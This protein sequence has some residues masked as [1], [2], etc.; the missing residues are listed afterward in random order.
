MIK[1]KKSLLGAKALVLIIVAIVAFS[2]IYNLGNKAYASVVKPE[3]KEADSFKKFVE[4]INQMRPGS[5]PFLLDFLGKN[6]AIIG[7]SK[8][9]ESYEC[10]DC[11]GNTRPKTI[12]NKPPDPKCED[13][14]CVCICSGQFEL[15]E[16]EFEGETTKF[17]QCRILEEC[18]ALDKDIVN[19]LTIPGGSNGYWK[20]GFLL[21]IDVP[22][23]NGLGPFDP[24]INH[25]V[26]EKRKNVMGFCTKDILEYNKK[27]LG[28]DS[29]IPKNIDESEV[30]I[31]PEDIQ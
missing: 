19:K 29:C 11:Y 10:V 22:G 2:A 8:G 24:K 14:A 13:D 6:S 5:S 17:G 15:V 18:E 4:D 20:D 1:N 21:V 26:V 23:L 25:I 3:R 12:V 16:T 9:S 31:E 28:F 27:E 7:F 30:V